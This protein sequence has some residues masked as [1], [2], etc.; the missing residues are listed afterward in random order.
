MIVKAGAMRKKRYKQYEKLGK[1]CFG[2]TSRK[3]TACFSRLDTVRMM[4]HSAIMGNAPKKHNKALLTNGKRSTM[5]LRRS[6]PVPPH[7]EMD[8]RA[9]PFQKI[10]D[11]ADAAAPTQKMT[12]LSIPSSCPGTSF[13]FHGH[14]KAR[15]DLRAKRLYSYFPVGIGF[16][17]SSIGVGW[18]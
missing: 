12:S 8:Q 18:L 15:S 4:N 11:T 13:F 2:A 17:F 9:S 16:P 14:Q 5:R 7:R 3:L 6:M 10:S 1:T